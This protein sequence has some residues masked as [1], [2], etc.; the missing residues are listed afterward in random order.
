MSK[1]N[2]FLFVCAGN[3]CR[4][5]SL[6]GILEHQLQQKRILAHIESCGLYASFLGSPPDQRMQEVAKAHGLKLENR[7]K[8]FEASFF[9]EFDAIFCV[10]EEIL[11]AV[12]ARAHQKEFLDKLY[13][14]THFSKNHRDQDIPD[15]YYG[16]PKGF[17]SVWSL[18]EEACEGIIAH[19]YP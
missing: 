5:P 1:L 17:E 19:F 11:E 18:M 7:A 6:K 10:T 9:D 14:A 2:S 3:I 16:G 13:L 8:L 15:P 12:A 4:S